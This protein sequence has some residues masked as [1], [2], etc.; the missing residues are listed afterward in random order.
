MTL[1]RW[2]GL[3][4]IVASV[5]ILWQMRAIVLLFL[6]AVVIATALNRFARRFQKSDVKRSYAILLAI[7]ITL[8]LIG[9][10]L[11]IILI[12]LTDQFN[13][14]LDLIPVAIN[15]IQWLVYE[16]RSKIPTGMMENLPTFDNFTQQLQTA[17]NWAIANIYLFFSN[18]LTIALNVLLVFVLALMLLAN[19]QQYRRILVSAFPAFYRQRAD[20]IFSRCEV[21]LVHYVAGI[22]LSMAFIGATST[23]VCEWVTCWIVSICSLHWCDRKCRSAYVARLAR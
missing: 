6:A 8:L 14:L 22:A 18:S 20:Q 3:F 4:A 13:Q 10:L 12:P 5:Y 17:A 23:S 2:L 1:G 15:Q 16:L 7:S 21:K 11:A 19:P 9:A